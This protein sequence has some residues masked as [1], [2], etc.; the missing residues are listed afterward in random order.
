MSMSP[1]S[2]TL[3]TMLFD[4]FCLT[5]T[6]D[7]FHDINYGYCMQLQSLLMGY[8][9]TEPHP[10]VSLKQQSKSMRTSEVE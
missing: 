6:A 5:T 8:T 9:T 7:S 1:A 3:S 10:S 4:A 2:L